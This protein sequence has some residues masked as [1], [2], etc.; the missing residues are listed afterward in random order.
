MIAWICVGDPAVM[1]E[2]VQHASFLMPSLGED[3]RLRR[4]GSA[5]EEITTWV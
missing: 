2:M 1:L 5:P 3:R 4:A